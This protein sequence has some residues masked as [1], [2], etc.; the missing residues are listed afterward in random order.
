V[1]VAVAVLLSARWLP[2]YSLSRPVS[3]IRLLA[4]L[5]AAAVYLQ[6]IIG[7]AMRHMGAGL[8]I[9]T[10]PQA[11]PTGSWLPA[12]H[13]A[14]VDINFTHTRVGAVIVTI[15]LLLTA[16]RTLRSHGSDSR[17]SRPAWGLVALVLIQFTL[18]VLVIWHMK[19]QSLTTL[20]VVNGAALLAMTVLLAMRTSRALRVASAS[21]PASH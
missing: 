10:F 13:S 17:L 11:S 18:G 5:S 19:P 8:A 2:A 16:W 7:A 1:N 20:H 15:L 12:T 14:Y 4:W 6:L 3:G 9:P 21:K